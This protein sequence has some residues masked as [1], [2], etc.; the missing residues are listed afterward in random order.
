MG[1]GDSTLGELLVTTFFES[2][3]PSPGLLEGALPSQ[4][5]LLAHSGQ[6]VGWLLASENG[7]ASKGFA[8][9]S[10]SLANTLLQHGQYTSLEVTSV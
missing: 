8:R 3:N 6:F 5:K 1:S 4:D 7:N 9:R 2:R 10:I